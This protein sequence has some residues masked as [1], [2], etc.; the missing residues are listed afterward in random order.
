MKGITVKRQ[1]F[2]LCT[3]LCRFT[4]N[5]GWRIARV[6]PKLDSKIRVVQEDDT[7]YLSIPSSVDMRRGQFCNPA[8]IALDHVSG[9]KRRTSDRK[10]PLV[11]SHRAF[12]RFMTDYRKGVY[13]DLRLGLA[14]YHVFNLYDHDQSQ[15]GHIWQRDSSE[16]LR[17][18]KSFTRFVGDN[19]D[20]FDSYFESI[21]RGRNLHSSVVRA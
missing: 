19:E 10:F 21:G 13:G 6:V 15:L 18:I 14:F 4:K 8:N 12:S 1:H 11:I 9:G 5:T 3:L 16:A 2:K 17:T 7:K 20:K